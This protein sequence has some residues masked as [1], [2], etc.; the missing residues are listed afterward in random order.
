[1]DELKERYGLRVSIL[2]VTNPKEIVS[3]VDEAVIILGK[4]LRC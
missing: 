3:V 4:S 1:L 2:D